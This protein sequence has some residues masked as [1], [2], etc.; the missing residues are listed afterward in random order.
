MLNETIELNATLSNA[1]NEIQA[2]LSNKT[3]EIACEITRI[4]DYNGSF[5]FTPSDEIQVIQTNG[6]LLLQNIT[7]NPI[8]SNYG[9]ITWNGSTMSIT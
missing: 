8:P 6:K 9:K 4:G 2:E 7:I 5:S 3:F 1:V